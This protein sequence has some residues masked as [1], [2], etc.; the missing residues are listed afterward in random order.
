MKEFEDKQRE[1]YVSYS[2]NHKPEEATHSVS[3]Y[4]DVGKYTRRTIIPNDEDSENAY[5]LVGIVN[6]HGENT[7]TG[8]YTSDNFDFKSKKWRSYNDS[9]VKD[10]K[11]HE[12]RYGRTQSSYIV[13][14]M[15]VSCYNAI[16][17]KSS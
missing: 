14:Y 9:S 13:F 12:V 11:E 8:H 10:I 7:G 15:H 4:E 2:A 1:Q 17:N 6:H 16:L 3:N 5:K